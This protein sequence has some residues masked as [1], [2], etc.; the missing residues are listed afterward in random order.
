MA[1]SV[2]IK[3]IPLNRSKT[4]EERRRSGVRDWTDFY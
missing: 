4:K 2:K 3:K 1:K